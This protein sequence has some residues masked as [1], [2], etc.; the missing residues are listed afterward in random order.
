MDPNEAI[1]IVYEKKNNNNKRIKVQQ[2]ETDRLSIGERERRFLFYI[3][4]SFLSQIYGNRTVDFRRSRRQSLSTRR[5]LRVGT[6]IVA[7][8]HTSRGRKFFYLCYFE[9]KCYVM[10]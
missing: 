9:P 3:F 7:F 2:Q 10:A 4:F 1:E 6:K 5:E 8:R